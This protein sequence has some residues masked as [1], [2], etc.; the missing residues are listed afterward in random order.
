MPAEGSVLTA[1]QRRKV[2]I[3]AWVMGLIA[4]GFYLAYIILTVIRAHR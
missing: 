4:A 3:T 1:E 2:R